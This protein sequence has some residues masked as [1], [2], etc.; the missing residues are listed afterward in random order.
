[1]ADG[2]RAVRKSLD[3]F[4]PDLVL[5]F[6][7]DQYENFREDIIPAFC[8][9]GMDEQFSLKPWHGNG[10]RP[11]RWNEPGDWEMKLH[12]QRDVAK[13]LATAP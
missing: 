5:I 7:D 3:A 10:G 8:V 13:H 11:N 6:G 2:F 1:M 12:G 9:F 4:N